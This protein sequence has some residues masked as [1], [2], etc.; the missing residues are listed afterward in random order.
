LVGALLFGVLTLPVMAVLMVPAAGLALLAHMAL[1]ALRVSGRR[2]YLVAGATAGL[3]F[4]LWLLP[5]Y[6]VC[7]PDAAPGR[8][9]CLAAAFRHDPAT[10]LL[11]L[12]VL[13]L[14]PGIV[15]GWAFHALLRP[16]RVTP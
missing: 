15:A 4:I 3:A 11:H 16:D 8:A 13:G 7:P 10:E 1:Q 14:I 12:A 2:A 9:A 5:G 6:V